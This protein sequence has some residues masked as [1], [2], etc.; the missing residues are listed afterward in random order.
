MHGIR[1]NAIA[2]G[3]ML[4]PATERFFAGGKAEKQIAAQ[5]PLGR[6]G[7]VQD[8]AAAIHW[9]LSDAAS[10]ITGHIL[11]VDGGFSAIRPMVRA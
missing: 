1:V 6:F 7:S 8:G 2:P 10:W 4:T 3:I 5:Y 9:L 11:P